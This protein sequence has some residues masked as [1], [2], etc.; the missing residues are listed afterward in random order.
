MQRDYWWAFWRKSKG[1]SWAW[2][3]LWGGLALLALSIGTGTGYFGVGSC[4][5]LPFLLLAAPYGWR[6]WSMSQRD[7]KVA[8][9]S[10][11]EYVTEAEKATPKPR[12]Q[13]VYLPSDQDRP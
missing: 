11:P 4:C 6:L 1:W 9:S 13:G 7:K 12:R 8:A 3:G 10:R 5:S 2:V